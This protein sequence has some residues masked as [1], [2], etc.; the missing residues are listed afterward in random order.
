[1]YSVV[2]SFSSAWR[3]LRRHLPFILF[4]GGKLYRK[5]CSQNTAHGR[6]A[7][8]QDLGKGAF[9]QPMT[10]Q[11]ADMQAETTAAAQGVLRVRKQHTKDPMQGVYGLEAPHPQT[12][13]PADSPMARRGGCKVIRQG[14]STLTH[15]LTKLMPGEDQH[16]QVQAGPTCSPQQAYARHWCVAC[17]FTSRT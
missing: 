9:W 7:S 2:R 12:G 3:A 13:K 17:L 10:G 14:R 6:N 16:R 15:K 8:M 11:H 5:S 4:L 1:M